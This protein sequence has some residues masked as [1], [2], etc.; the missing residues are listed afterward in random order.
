MTLTI[1]AQH[2]KTDWAFIVKKEDLHLIGADKGLRN[3]SWFRNEYTFSNMCNASFFTSNNA[4]GPFMT[5]IRIKTTNVYRWWWLGWGCDTAYISNTPVT[6]GERHTL[7]YLV[8][9]TPL[10]IKNSKLVSKKEMLQSCSIKF[11]NRKCPRTAIGILDDKIF[12]YIT[13]SATILELQKKMQSFGCSYAINLDGGG[14]TFINTADE[15]FPAWK[16]V[17]R[18]YPN[19]LAW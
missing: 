17:K 19:L 7:K 8:A 6:N 15:Q 18:K 1:N 16:K 13:K 3:L 11:F 12:I 9:G 4:V 10:L 2:K 5:D 14:S